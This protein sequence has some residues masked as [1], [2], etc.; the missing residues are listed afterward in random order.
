LLE[1]GF[2]IREERQTYLNLDLE[3]ENF[4]LDFRAL[5]TAAAIK[6]FLFSVGFS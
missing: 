6:R 5:F 3:K 2:D 4:L 1:I